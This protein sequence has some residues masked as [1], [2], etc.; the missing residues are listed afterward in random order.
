MTEF[1][2]E[3]TLITTTTIGFNLSY[4]EDT[5]VVLAL[6]TEVFTD[7][8]IGLVAFVWTKLELTDKQLKVL[9][10]LRLN[11][12]SSSVKETA[13]SIFL[14]NKDRLAKLVVK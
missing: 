1:K 12:F 2:I 14:V 4:N 9:W 3:I 10:K 8:A 13:T 11:I 6:P 5:S 7:L